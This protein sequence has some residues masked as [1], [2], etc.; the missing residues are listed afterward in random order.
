MTW[1]EIWEINKAFLRQQIGAGKQII[2]SHDPS[3]A[4]GF[5]L[6]EVAYLEDLGYRFVKENW[7]WKAIR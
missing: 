1:D 4:T 2:L 7:V 5:F 6:R 3:K